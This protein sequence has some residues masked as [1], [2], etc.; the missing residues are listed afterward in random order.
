MRHLGTLNESSIY[1]KSSDVSQISD[2]ELFREVY[3]RSQTDHVSSNTINSGVS[4]LGILTLI[5]QIL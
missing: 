1:R 3:R 2:F 4:F 5:F